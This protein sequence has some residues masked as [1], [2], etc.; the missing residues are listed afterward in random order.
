MSY[1]DFLASKRR[2]YAGDGLAGDVALPPVLHDWQVAITRWALRKGRA[3]IFADCGLGKTFMQVSWA[4]ALNV[5]TLFL[6][7][8]CVAEQTVEEAAKLGV[9]LYYAEDADAIQGPLT[10]T[11]YER[12]DKFDPA[13]F[14]AVVLDES[15]ILKAFDGKTRTALIE[16]FKHARYRLCCTA[17]PS[18]ND[19]SEL[20]NHAEFLGLMSRVEFL[21]TW[22]VKVDQGLRTTEHHGWRLKGHAR[23]PFFRW[24]SSWAVALRSPADIGYSD[25]GYRLPALDIIDRVIEAEHPPEGAL[26]HDMALKG[27]Q[28]RLA[29][30]R[31]SLVDRVEAVA[32]LVNGSRDQFVVWCALNDESEALA[33]AIPDAV[34]VSGSDTY[35]EKR[36]AVQAFLDGR[37][38][39]LISKPRIL[40]FGLNLQRCHRMVFVGLGDSYETYYQCIRRCWRF[41]Q[42]HPV[43]VSI[44][45]SEA[46]TGVVQNVRR[47]ETTADALSRELLAEMRDF[48]REEIC[49]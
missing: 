47:K 32:A 12:L 33:E 39:V 31:G 45:V 15:S 7:P 17:T 13:R 35:A 46:E 21:A 36:G 24:L 2:V 30:R 18:P 25:A 22:F 14:G 8:L 3:A 11:N 10:I 49:A 19:I 6:A 41:G 27:I 5:P 38:R 28:G 20:G 1:L 43:E 42:T 40:G 23:Q 16:S 9:T 37:T 44:V 34:E 26:F 4:A 48:E 29:A